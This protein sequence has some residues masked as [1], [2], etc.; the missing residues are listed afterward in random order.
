ML[1]L[2]L[3]TIQVSH[4][5]LGAGQ[6][7]AIAVRMQAI[8]DQPIFPTASQQRSHSA[9]R[10]QGL[11]GIGYSVFA[12]VGQEAEQAT[13]SFETSRPIRVSSYSAVDG[14]TDMTNRTS[15]QS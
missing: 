13:E 3:D 15:G 11:C 14:K 8:L 1:N 9:R 4:D 5:K 12:G 10:L 2:A 7:N 6:A